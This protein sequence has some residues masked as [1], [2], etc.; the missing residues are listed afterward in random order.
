MSIA[1][2]LLE[3]QTHS[4]ES[5]AGHPQSAA[6]PG[7]SGAGGTQRVVAERIGAPIPVA[8]MEQVHARIGAEVSIVYAQTESSC[9][10][11]QTLPDD[12]FERKK[13]QISHQKIP[14]YFQFVENY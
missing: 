1:C 12:P 8:L 4:Q 5:H 9:T 2:S 6:A 14:R 11:T 7:S 13:G 3:G 10:M